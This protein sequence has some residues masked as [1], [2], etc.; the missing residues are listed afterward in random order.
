MRFGRVYSKIWSDCRFLSLADQD[1]LLYFYLLSS[2]RCNSIGFFKIGLGAME[3]EFNRGKD[4]IKAGLEHLQKEGLLIYK[5]GWI[6]FNRFLKW[7]APTSPNHAKKCAQVLND[8]MQSDAPGELVCSFLV[9]AR[10][11]L[12]CLGKDD[13]K[14]YWELF[15]NSLD[16]PLAIETVGGKTVLAQ[17][18]EGSWSAQ[19]NEASNSSFE[20]L[21]ETSARSSKSPNPTG[22]SQVLSKCLASTTED[23][24]NKEKKRKVKEAEKEKEQFSFAASKCNAKKE[25]PNPIGEGLEGFSVVCGDETAGEVSSDAVE[26]VAETFPGIDVPRAKALAQRKTLLKEAP[27]PADGLS[28]DSWFLDLCESNLAILGGGM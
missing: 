5:D 3:D 20:D 11:V 24:P 19:K 1:K 7:N 27:L 9:A 25:N 17:C 13:R 12:S 14:T 2:E 26:L 23:L 15:K 8:T 16:I 22:L 21:N 18:F 28:C 6:S 4:D 10:T